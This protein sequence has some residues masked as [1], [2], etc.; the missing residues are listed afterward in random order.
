MQAGVLGENMKKIKA[1][2][3]CGY[4]IWD[5]PECNSGNRLRPALK[6]G[7]CGGCY[8]DKFAIKE[9]LLNG[10]IIRGYNKKKQDLAKRKAHAENKV[11]KVVF[12]K[13]HSAIE[14]VLRIRKEEHQSWEV[15]QTIKDLQTETRTHPLLGYVPFK[16]AQE[17]EKP[18]PE[19][20][21]AELDEKTLRRIA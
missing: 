12:P 15:G 2:Y 13:N 16:E 6:M 18:E 1:R 17:K 10:T 4:W 7:F 19:I 11:Y 8:P 3:N 20:V 21:Y 5:C 9:S 14:D